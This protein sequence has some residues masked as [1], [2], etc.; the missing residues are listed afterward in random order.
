MNLIYKFVRFVLK[1]GTILNKNRN[2]KN[3]VKFFI[4]NA[5]K[6]FEKLRKLPFVH[7]IK[8]IEQ[9]NLNNK[10]VTS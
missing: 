8:T 1:I 3:V 10:D 5:A 4:N 2:V 6:P 9:R 7:I